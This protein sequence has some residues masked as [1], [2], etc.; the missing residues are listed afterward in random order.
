MHDW[1]D[2]ELDSD[3]DSPLALLPLRCV[4]LRK[5][6]TLSKLCLHI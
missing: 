4:A 1:K 5:L 2:T 3:S 6:T